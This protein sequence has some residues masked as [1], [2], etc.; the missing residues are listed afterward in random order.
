MNFYIT[1]SRVIRNRPIEET[2]Y[3]IMGLSYFLYSA[4]ILLSFATITVRSYNGSHCFSTNDK[5]FF[6]DVKFR[7]MMWVCFTRIRNSTDIE[8]TSWY[9]FKIVSKIF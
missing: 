8:E 7:M 4:E 6:I 3:S 2:E 9:F 1:I 5:A